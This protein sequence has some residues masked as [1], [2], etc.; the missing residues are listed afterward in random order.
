MSSNY[1]TLEELIQHIQD[2]SIIHFIRQ[3]LI[4]EDLTKEEQLFFIDLFTLYE[5]IK[6][7]SIGEAA[8]DES[9]KYKL[10]DRLNRSPYI[11]NDTTAIELRY[12]SL[13][14]H[15]LTKAWDTLAFE[16]NKI[17]PTKRQ[18][19]FY[20]IYSN[21]IEKLDDNYVAKIFNVYNHPDL[22]LICLSIHET[23]KPNNYYPI[24]HEMGHYIGL[25]NRYQRK[26]VLKQLICYGIWERVFQYCINDYDSISRNLPININFPSNSPRGAIRQA[27]CEQLFSYCYNLNEELIKYID[28]CYTNKHPKNAC[29]NNGISK[30]PEVNDDFHLFAKEYA[31]EILLYIHQMLIDYVNEDK[32][33]SNEEDIIHSNVKEAIL[34]LLDDHRNRN[35]KEINRMLDCIEEPTADCFMIAMYDMTLQ[36]YLDRVLGESYDYWKKMPGT[37]D[38]DTFLKYVA[39]PQLQIRILSICLAMGAEPKELLQKKFTFNEKDKYIYKARK[40]LK[41]I[42][43]DMLQMDFSETVNNINQSNL[44]KNTKYHRFDEINLLRFA[45]NTINPQLVVSAY[46]YNLM[47]E[48]IQLHLFSDMHLKSK[49]PQRCI[50][51]ELKRMNKKQTDNQSYPSIAVINNLKNQLKQF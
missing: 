29:S 10:V 35:Y 32:Q 23:L 44:N 28:T 5:N 46:I 3:H 38:Y 13:F 43:A 47:Q 33:T 37:H 17:D 6:L 14:L 20:L 4:P 49:S 42:Y 40:M 51:D 50:L 36:D 19:V 27:Y 2:E 8:S 30:S 45:Q 31:S 18:H 7:N 48:Y 22:R 26:D 16:R 9:K 21:E 39:Q 15:K 24:L 11:N 34:K 41:S 12:F 25:R 1:R